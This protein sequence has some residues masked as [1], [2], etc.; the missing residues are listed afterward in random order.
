MDCHLIGIC[1]D[2]LSKAHNDYSM[3]QSVTILENQYKTISCSLLSNDEDG[4]TNNTIFVVGQ[5]S[6]VVQNSVKDI[7]T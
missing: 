7:V 5:E 6:K 3:Q 2:F 4:T 1:H